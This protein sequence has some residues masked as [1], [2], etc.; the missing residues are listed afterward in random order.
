MGWLLITILLP[1]VAPLLA[2]LVFKLFPQPN[3]LPLIAP[4]KDGQL[5]WGALGFSAS[6]LYEIFSSGSEGMTIT[7]ASTGWMAGVLTVSLVFSA[8]IAA[9]GSAF[10]KSPTPPPGVSLVK[11][12]AC[13]L[14][15]VMLSLLAAVLYAVVHY[16]LKN[17]G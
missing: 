10:P 13:F 14:A 9:L 8:M 17:H 7:A 2:L 12:F 15:S 11:H 16:T 6:G 4:F 5:C 3:P 1:L